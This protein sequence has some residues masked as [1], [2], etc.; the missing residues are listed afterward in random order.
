MSPRTRGPGSPDAGPPPEP[1]PPLA[2]TGPVA[3]LDAVETELRRV[4]G[5]ALLDDARIEAH[6]YTALYFPWDGAG[7]EPP[8]RVAARLRVLTTRL[9]RA[10]PE[11]RTVLPPT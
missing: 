9:H 2:S 3:R 11:T 4:G 1:G 7:D 10:H 5:A 6:T 8:D